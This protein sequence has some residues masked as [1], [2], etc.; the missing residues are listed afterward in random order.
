MLKFKRLSWKD[1]AK[2]SK[3]D[4]GK[5]SKANRDFPNTPGAFYNACR[6]VCKRCHYVMRDI[7]P[8]SAGGE[9]YHTTLDKN[10]KPHT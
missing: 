6:A 5:K 10:L 3:R 9:F 7:E 8:S 1:K 4:T 2:I